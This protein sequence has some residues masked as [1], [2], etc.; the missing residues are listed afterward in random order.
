MERQ[1]GGGSRYRALSGRLCTT[2]GRGIKNPFFY[3][4]VFLETGIENKNCSDP[5][6][7]NSWKCLELNGKAKG[8]QVV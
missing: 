8:T 1:I 5:P 3:E 6:W 2:A 4:N 7:G